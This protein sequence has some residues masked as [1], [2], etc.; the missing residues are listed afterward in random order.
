M[1][2]TPPKNPLSSE[3][4]F[5]GR[6][7]RVALDTFEL[8]NGKRVVHEVARHGP[9]A[10]VVP[11][12]DTGEILLVHQFRPVLNQWFWEI[13]AGLVEGG[14]SPIDSARR[15]LTE[16]TGWRAKKI[17]P[18]LSFHTTFGFSDE[19]IH[20]FKAEGL[21]QDKKNLDENEILEEHFFPIPEIRAML[22]RREITDSKT[23]IGLGH[24]L[25]GI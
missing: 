6:I 7:I 4:I 14:E 11:I 10:A 19:V 24:Y 1:K 25:L 5:D 23:L 13:P 22:Q 15:E 3:K 12:S 16:E 18:L 21:A 9:A 8:P 20:I 17:E 2:S